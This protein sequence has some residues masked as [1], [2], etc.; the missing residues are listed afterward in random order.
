M[1]IYYARSLRGDR[2]KDPVDTYAVREL[3]RRLGHRPQ[4][5]LAHDITHEGRNAEQY[6][7]DRDIAWLDQCDAMIAE[8]SGPSHG[9]GYEIAYAYFVRKIPVLCMAQTGASKS[10]MLSRVD[11]KWYSTAEKL[12][13]GITQ[14]LAVLTTPDQQPL[15]GLV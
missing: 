11:V 15:A 7:H 4:F 1:N 14:W 9:V 3:L 8:V 12:E 13:S 6:L 2:P 5:D 10:A